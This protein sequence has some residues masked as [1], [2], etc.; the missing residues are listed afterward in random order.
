MQKDNTTLV[1]Y[2]GTI[3]CNVMNLKLKELNQEEQ[4]ENQDPN[5]DGEF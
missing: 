5:M 4:K 1:S 2:Y 3:K